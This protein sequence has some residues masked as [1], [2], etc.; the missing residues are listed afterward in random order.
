M[1]KT[2]SISPKISNETKVSTLSILIEFSAQ[3]LSHS[4]KQEKE[5]KGA[6]CM[7]LCIKNLKDYQKPL[8]SDK[9]KNFWQISRINQTTYKNSSFLCADNEHVWKEIR[10][11]ISSQ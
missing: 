1:G 3:T 6:G 11:T 9:K 4:K 5:I 2:G 8:K 10:K 7:I